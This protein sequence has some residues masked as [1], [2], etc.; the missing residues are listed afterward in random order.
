MPYDMRLIQAFNNVLNIDAPCQQIAQ[1][2]TLYRGGERPDAEAFPIRLG[3]VFLSSHPAYARAYAGYWKR[4]PYH[5]L[6]RAITAREIQVAVVYGMKSI[7]AVAIDELKLAPSAQAI[8]WQRDNLIP[9]ARQA[10]RQRVDGILFLN[11][12]DSDADEFL[13]E[14]TSAILSLQDLY[15]YREDQHDLQREKTVLMAPPVGALS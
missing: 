7:V 8:H 12:D 15:V 2:K 3:N 11:K 4:H 14:N 1:G 9:I 6:Y 10:L 5:Y 13:L